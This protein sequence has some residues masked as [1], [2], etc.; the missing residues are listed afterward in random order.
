MA[1]LL[2]GGLVA[3]ALSKDLVPRIA[4]LET[5]GITP[6]LAIVRVGERDS[7]LSYERG[8]IKR[9][10]GLGLGLKRFV[11]PA[12]CAQGELMA[13]IDTV[14]ADTGIHGCLMLRPLP[15]HLDESAACARLNSEKDVD[16]ITQ[17]SLYGVFANQQ[18]GF[19]P[20]TADACMQ[21]LRRY[22]CELT[23]ANAV[24]LGRSLV[25]GKPVSMMLQAANATV[26]MCHTRTKG[27]AAKCASADIL[28]VAV[29]RPCMVGADFVRKGQIVIDVGINWDEDA[30]KLRGDV[31][32]DVVE[33][34]VAGITPVP[35]GVGNVTT[36]ILASHVVE[37]A[38]RTQGK[39]HR[40]N[41]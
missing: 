2:R 34:L 14:N 33:P 8:A 38:E 3:E 1:A 4:K 32:F 10:K 12:D 6:T 16:G 17:G 25:V 28:V 40:I 18:V 29:G 39:F 21:I 36:A 15:M 13:V 11:L 35:G 22:E 27:L 24:V 41:Q 31:D 37:A 7:D 20:C 23:G 9:C 19:P 5:A 26:T 30:G